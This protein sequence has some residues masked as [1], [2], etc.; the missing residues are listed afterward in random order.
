[1]QTNSS[2]ISTWGLKDICWQ[3]ICKICKIICKTLNT[4][5]MLQD[6]YLNKNMDT[7]ETWCCA[8]G[9]HC[10]TDITEIYDIILSL[11]FINHSLNS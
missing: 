6:I 2:N 11:K 1:M 10:H 4:S 9:V 3:K 8:D 7:H 5:H